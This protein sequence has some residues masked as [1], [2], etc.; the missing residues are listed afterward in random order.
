MRIRTIVV[1]TCAGFAL[2]MPGPVSADDGEAETVTPSKSLRVLGGYRHPV[3]Q[4]CR[5]LETFPRGML[6][7][8]PSNRN[9]LDFETPHGG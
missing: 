3:H 2:S 8:T 9:L 5:S 7:E 1:A 6:S 4:A